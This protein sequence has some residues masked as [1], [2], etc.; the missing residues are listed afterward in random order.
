MTWEVSNESNNN[1]RDVTGNK[2]VLMQCALLCPFFLFIF[3]GDY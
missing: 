1:F 3:V 2:H